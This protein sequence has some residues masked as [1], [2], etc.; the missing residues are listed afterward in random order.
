MS[1]FLSQLTMRVYQGRRLIYEA[2]PDEL[3]GLSRNVYLG[4]LDYRDSVNLTVELDVPITL[5]NE[6]ANRVG[7][8]DWVFTVETYHESSDKPSSNPKTG[9]YII[10]GAAAL[11]AISGAALLILFISK[12]RKN[13]K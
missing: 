4:S 10:M 13:R 12:R 8:V 6:Y 5:G 3:D 1:D 9:D 2:S 11:M 7:E